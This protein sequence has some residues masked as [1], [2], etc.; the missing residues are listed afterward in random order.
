MCANEYAALK[1]AV[2]KS[3][4]DKSALGI[5]GGGN[6]SFF[7]RE[8]TGQP[9]HISEYKGV[10]SYSPEELVITVKAGTPVSELKKLLAENRQILGFDPPEF[11][12]SS[13]R[14]STIGGAIAAGLSG[15]SRP[16]KGGVQDF[17]LGVKM[18]TGTGEILK[19]GG[20]VIK[21][22]AG[23][24]ISR[25]LVGSMGCLGIILEVS[26]RTLPMPEYQRTLCLENE[27]PDDAILLMNQLAGKP[28]PISAASWLDGITRIKLSGF[29]HSIES[30]TAAI[31]GTVDDIE[32][33]NDNPFWAQLRDQS[34]EFFDHANNLDK[35]IIK[36]CVK[37][38]TASLITNNASLLDWGGAQ[39]WHCVDKSEVESIFKTY[40]SKGQVC[41][42]KNGDRQQEVFHP[43]PE[44]IKKLHIRLKNTFDPVGILNPGRMYSFL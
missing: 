25:L 27:N 29:K 31:G 8:I 23:F 15:P 4:S 14:E 11:P 39:R 22:V 32:D 12:S 10:I 5:Y 24:D 41:Y 40:F 20:Q 16:F 18:M 17:I 34:L 26:L 2:E 43:L 9:L 3:H 13:P 28:L 33:N 36:A 37:P 21:N 38:S 7:G 19:F 44:G 1:D 30:A 42:F 35:V 6:K